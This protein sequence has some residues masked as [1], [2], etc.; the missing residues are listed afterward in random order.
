M[1]QWNNEK[2]TL[3]RITVNLCY[4]DCVER[5]LAKLLFVPG[6]QAKISWFNLLAMTQDRQKNTSRA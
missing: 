3:L 5:S 2:E 4:G 6:L 1:P